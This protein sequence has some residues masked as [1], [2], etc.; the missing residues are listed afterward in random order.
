MKSLKDLQD[1]FNTQK[2]LLSGINRSADATP[3]EVIPEDFKA[4]EEYFYNDL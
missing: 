1:A 2:E 4:G 3:N